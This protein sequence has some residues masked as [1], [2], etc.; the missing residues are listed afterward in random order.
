M[1]GLPTLHKRSFHKLIKRKKDG[2]MNQIK[3]SLVFTCMFRTSDHT[4]LVNGER[5]SKRGSHVGTLGS[6]GP[7]WSEEAAPFSVYLIYPA[8]CE[9]EL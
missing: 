2:H 7:A 5:Y 1:V 9:K 6:V 8:R 4:E 3:D